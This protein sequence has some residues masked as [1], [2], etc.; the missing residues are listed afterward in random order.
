MSAG[1]FDELKGSTTVIVRPDGT[2]LHAVVAGE[3][4]TVVLVHGYG[5]TL[6]TWSLVQPALVARGLRVVAYDHRAH[7][8]STVGRDGTTSRA[9]FDDLVAVVEHVGAEDV[10]LVGHS[11]G[12]FTVMGALAQRRLRERTRAAVLVAAETGTL[13]RGAA[14]SV[15]V[16]APL[17]GLGILPAICRTPVLGPY[18]AAELCGPD[19]SA[20]IIAATQRMLGEGTR[21]TRG[22]IAMMNT[23]SVAA[24]LPAI[25]LPITVIWGDADNATPGWHSELI[26]ER[27][28]DARL[29]AVPRVG[30]MANWEAADAV[31][32]AVLAAAPDGARDGAGAGAGSAA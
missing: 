10:T 1:I 18:A 13:L 20:D 31:I 3:G 25:E 27:A 9:L 15:R 7:G 17:A 11:M 24:A 26:V 28:P 2:R 4:P 5:G 6:Q 21:A 29:V 30:H 32:D 12:T 19:A 16:L 23:E 22:F 8:C 14:P